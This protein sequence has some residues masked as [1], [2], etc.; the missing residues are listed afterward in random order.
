MQLMIRAPHSGTE[1]ALVW[2]MPRKPFIIDSASP[3]H[4]VA[5][6]NNRDWF[7]IPLSEVWTIFSDYLSF[8][9]F[10]YGVRIHAFVLMQNHFHLIARFPNGNLSSSMNY[11]MRE[12]SRVIASE[13]NRINHVFGARVF[14]SRLHSNLYFEHAY[15]YVYRNPIEAGACSRVEDYAFSTFRGLLGIDK[16]GIPVEEDTLLFESGNFESHIEWLNSAPHPEAREAVRYALTRPHFK[17]PKMKS[18]K[19]LHWLENER[20]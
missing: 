19:R 1:L 17:L 3:Y 4:L 18:S 2:R 6:S 20:Y 15:K 14:R 7:S 5:R 9:H 16:I 12:T 10:A 13:S 8:I 11:F